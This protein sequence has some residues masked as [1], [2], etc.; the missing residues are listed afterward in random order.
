MNGFNEDSRLLKITGLIP[1]ILEDHLAVVPIK[2][3]R[4]KVAAYI[5]LNT[6]SASFASL[7]FLMP[8]QLP[9]LVVAGV[10]GDVVGSIVVAIGLVVVVA[11]T[12]SLSFGLH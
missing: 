9:V 10:V 8:F 11:V 1:T 7:W 4:L 6:Y 3:S 12:W 5:F 2:D